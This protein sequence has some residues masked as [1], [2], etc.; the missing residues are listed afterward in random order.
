MDQ[1][2]DLDHEKLIT[3]GLLLQGVFVLCY[4]ICSFVVA[5]TA[6]MGFNAVLTALLYIFYV[7]GTYHVLQRSKMPLAIGFVLGVSVMITFLSLMTAIFWGQ[8]SNCSPGYYDVK[9]Y[10]CTNPSAYGATCAFATLLFL[11]QLFFTS[12]LVLWRDEFIQDASAYDDIHGG[13]SSSNSTSAGGGGLPG[14]EGGAQQA[15]YN[16]STTADL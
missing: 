5:S 9:R 14:Y 13:G 3:A 11:I 12:A 1:L 10:S 15:S 7:A 8:L 4:T 6:N 16:Q 2:G